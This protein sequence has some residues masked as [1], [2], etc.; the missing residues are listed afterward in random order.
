MIVVAARKQVGAFH[1]DVEFEVPGTGV[2]ALFGPSGAGKSL[3]LSLIAGLLC[4]DHGAI[5]VNGEIYDDT[6]RGVHVAPQDR[7]L[8]MAFQDSLLLPH[9]NALDNVAMAVRH[10]DRAAR[11]AQAARELERVGLQ[12][13]LEAAP[14]SLSGG[15]RQRVSLAR[16]LAGEPRL[17]LL[18]EPF[19]ALDLPLRRRLRLLVSEVA[20][21]RR[22]P[23]LFVTHDRAELTA[24]ADFAVLFQ[25]GTAR[26]VLPSD[27]VPVE[28]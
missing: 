15:E 11:R 19:S 16:A 14:R 25:P 26:E 23:V 10:P 1:L 2:S 17:L 7:R 6:E 13:R 22:I 12:D 9:R 28:V 21:E 3:T 8:G 20:A 4:P 5:L 27:R 18:D 24:L